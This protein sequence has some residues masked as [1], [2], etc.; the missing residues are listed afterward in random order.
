MEF[1]G[2]FAIKD[3]TDARK[4][5]FD[6]DNNGRTIPGVPDERKRVQQIVDANGKPVTELRTL[7][8]TVVCVFQE[9]PLFTRLGLIS[10]RWTLKLFHCL[11]CYERLHPNGSVSQKAC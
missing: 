2:L 9:E 7:M 6:K 1:T 10:W 4:P 11:T 8:E 3:L 5:G